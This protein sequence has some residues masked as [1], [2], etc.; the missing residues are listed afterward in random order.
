[1]NRLQKTLDLEEKVW[2]R[3]SE[4]TR[5]EFESIYGCWDD[6]SFEERV[7]GLQ[8]YRSI[9]AKREEEVKEERRREE[10]RQTV[11]PVIE[12]LKVLGQGTDQ[13]NKQLDD[14]R[15]NQGETY[16]RMGQLEGRLKDRPQLPVMNQSPPPAA[17][18][19]VY[20]NTPLKMN[21][22]YSKD[23]P[24]DCIDVFQGLD[25]HRYGTCTVGDQVRRKE[26]LPRALSSARKQC[27]CPSKIIRECDYLSREKVKLS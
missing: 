27:G 21:C 24:K 10:M 4:T 15:T 20:I 22:A 13:I 7:A 9:L 5:R 1:M 2:G 16:R 26:I 17:P 25:G 23:G 3:L 8:S 6:L 12:Y 19:N 14:I 18:Q 11:A